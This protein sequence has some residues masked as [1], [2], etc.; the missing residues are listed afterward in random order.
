MPSDIDIPTIDLFAGP[1]GLSEGFARPGHFASR[2]G[3]RT[4]LSIEKDPFARMTLE[5]RAFVRQFNG[6]LPRSFYRYLRRVIDRDK[7]FSLHPE[8]AKVASR[9]AWLATLGEEPH[10]NVWERINAALGGTKPDQPWVLLGGPPCQVYSTVGRSRM[11]RVFGEKFEKD[12]RH[13][14][15]QEYLRILADHTPPVFIFENV[16]GLLSSSVAGEST[17][18]A[19]MRDLRNPAAAS[20]GG[21]NDHHSQESAY[22][23]IP[24]TSTLSD[25]SRHLPRL[26]ED[27]DFIIYSENFGIPQ[28]RHRLIIMGV[29]RDLVSTGAIDNIEPLLPRSKVS[30]HSVIAGL[31]ELAGQVSRRGKSESSRIE[32]MSGESSDV[33]ADWI[34]LHSSGE[35]ADE[36]LEIIQETIR[37]ARKSD[38]EES[39]GE[40]IKGR[41]QP[42]YAPK[43]F[44]DRQIGGITNHQARSHM[45]SDLQRYLFA[46]C[47]AELNGRSPKLR[48]FPKVLQPAHGSAS[49]GNFADR[50]RVQLLDKPATTITSHI[51][52]DGHYF[53]HPDPVQCRA[54]TV[55][56]AARVQTFPDNYFFEGPR[57]EQYKQ[58]GN[59]VPPL[60]A[61]QIADL[62][63]G[64]L[65]R[66]Q[67]SNTRSEAQSSPE[68]VAQIS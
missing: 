43:W 21:A 55:R 47:F 60:L 23:L 33:P 9:E 30:L 11:R 28:A 56:E 66:W 34:V 32:C 24:L 67:K 45:P 37:N 36:L 18:Q 61:S 35:I 64:I 7:L 16:K 58:V 59:A 19:I 2:P 39:G 27:R 40:F 22:E 68:P 50:F 54:L 63:Y 29:R 3:F 8:Q 49:S 13:F 31:P 46:T 51:S 15:Y 1:G 10:E 42:G 41:F 25:S 4:V 57:T 14:L 5:L 12:G 52:K 26:Y 44:Y 48:E 17:L 53:I 6:D 38:A 62:V 65:E 20:A